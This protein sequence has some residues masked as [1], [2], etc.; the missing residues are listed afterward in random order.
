[1]LCVHYYKCKY[2]AFSIMLE[3]LYLPLFSLMTDCNFVCVHLV[4]RDVPFFVLKVSLNIN[5]PTSVC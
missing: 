3:L 4:W 2:N 5:R 1:M